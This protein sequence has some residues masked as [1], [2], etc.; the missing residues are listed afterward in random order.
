MGISSA[1]CAFLHEMN[2]EIVGE[3]LSIL[4]AV[5]VPSNKRVNRTGITP[6]EALESGVPLVFVAGGR[7]QTPLSGLECEMSPRART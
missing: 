2:K 6:I 7:D 1:K 5:T 4:A 3:I